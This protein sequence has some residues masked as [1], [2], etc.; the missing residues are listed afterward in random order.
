MIIFNNG[1]RLVESASELPS[2]T[3]EQL[4]LLFADFETTS[5]DE[6]LDALNPWHHCDVLGIAI[7]ASNVAGA[8]Y[9]P[10]NH[11]FGTNIDKAIV[12]QWWLDILSR[13]KR[14]INHNI[15]YDAHVSANTLG[16]LPLCELYCSVVQSKILDSDRQFRGGYGLDALSLLWLGEDIQPYERKLK[17]ALGKSKD[18]GS[19]RASDMAEYAGQDVITNRRLYRYI[20]SKRPEQCNAVSEMEIELTQVLFQMEREG[21]CIDPIELMVEEIAV[22]SR[23]LEIETMLFRNLGRTIN[24]NSRDDVEDVFINQ[25]GLPVMART[26]ETDDG[27]PDE[28]SGISFNKAAMA[29]YLTHPDVVGTKIEQVVTG[30]AEYRQLSTF[31]SLFLRTYQELHTVESDGTARLHSD[32]NQLVRTGRMSGRKPNPQQLNKRAKKLIHP[33]DGCAF[34]SFD[35]SQI[36]FRVIVHYINDQHCIRAYNENPDTDFHEWVASLAGIKRKPAKTLNFQNGYGGGRK[37]CV[38]S[39]SINTD[40]VGGVVGRVDQMIANGQMAESQRKAMQEAL[41][42][43]LANKVYDDYHT[44]LPTLK[45]TSRYAARVCRERGYVYNMH[46][47]RR[48]LDAAHAHNAF[49]SVC[50]GEAADI[51]KERTNALHRCIKDTPI[52]MVANVHDETLLVGPK[53]IMKDKRVQDAIAWILE[54]PNNP[55][56]VPLRVSCGY[57]EKD[58]CEASSEPKDGGTSVLHQYDANTVNCDDPLFFLKETSDVR[59]HSYA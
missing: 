43:Q 26:E 45:P 21:L 36:E 13:T 44:S 52:K 16:V 3:D 30:V 41:C 2:F 24:P 55:L 4:Q 39:L 17:A 18:Y 15:K 20:E 23:M 10:V 37:K 50:Q 8:W 32:Y 31:R 1:A 42:V 48:H 12:A 34:L 58:W 56:R 6:K 11:E 29:K 22:T 28:E 57:S 9:V 40:I 38:K 53:E 54:H 27:E 33:P 49:N 35:Q 46:G 5:W 59:E 25:F 14:W 47:R 7:T 19:T 51:Q